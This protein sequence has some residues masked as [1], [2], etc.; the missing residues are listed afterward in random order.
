MKDKD[1]TIGESSMLT[2][3]CFSASPKFWAPL[4]PILFSDR[5]SMV[6]VCVKY[7]R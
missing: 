1:E 2:L 6:S 4:A 7:E 5:K 3:F